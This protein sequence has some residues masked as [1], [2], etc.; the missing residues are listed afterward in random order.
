MEK[1]THGGIQT[2]LWSVAIRGYERR[3]KKNEI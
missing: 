3:E 2:G 1:D